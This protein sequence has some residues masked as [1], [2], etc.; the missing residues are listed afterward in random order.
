MPLLGQAAMLLSF[1][2]AVDAVGEHDQWHTHEHLPE[3]LSIPGFVRGSRWIAV[4]GQPRYFVMY[5][6]EQLATLTSPPYL[7]RLNNPSPWTS[8]MMVHYR[9]MT[10]G[11]CLVTGSFGSGIGCVGLLIRFKPVQGK[12]PALREWLLRDCL[13]TLPRRSG[14]GSVHLLEAAV[15]PEMTTEQRIRGADA[16]WDWALFFTGY[17][18]DLLATLVRSDFSCSRLQRHGVLEPVDAMY[19]LQYSLVN[20]ELDAHQHYDRRSVKLNDRG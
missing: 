3:R 10:R 5:E 2:V 18:E 7:D 20:Q 16:G 14:I 11:F 17:D 4:R 15:T 6:V 8:K 13:P 19:Q 1:D 9:G 12:E